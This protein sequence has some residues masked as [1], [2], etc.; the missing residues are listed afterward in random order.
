MY[1]SQLIL[2]FA[3]SFPSALSHFYFPGTQFTRGN[4][5]VN[6]VLPLV[7]TIDLTWLGDLRPKRNLLSFL[8][9]NLSLCNPIH[10]QVISKEVN[11]FHA[12]Y[13]AVLTKA[14]DKLKQKEQLQSGKETAGVKKGA[15]SLHA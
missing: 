14:M 5:V 4:I 1:D 11:N 3:P 15:R 8:I 12:Q 7:R 10:I 6:S 2:L 13:F 9:T